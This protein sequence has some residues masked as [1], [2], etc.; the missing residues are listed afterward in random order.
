MKLIINPFYLFVWILT[1]ITML[2]FLPEKFNLLF[3]GRSHK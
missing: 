1:G 2:F 3:R